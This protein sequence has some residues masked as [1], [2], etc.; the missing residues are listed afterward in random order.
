MEVFVETFYSGL[1]K[2]HIS[3]GHRNKESSCPGNQ[4]LFSPLKDIQ[5]EYALDSTR[6]CCTGE[7][8]QLVEL[9]TGQR[10]GHFEVTVGVTGIFLK[11]H[12]VNLQ[13]YIFNVSSEEQSLFYI[14][15]SLRAFQN[16]IFEFLHNKINHSKFSSRFSPNC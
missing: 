11:I 1:E 8:L 6:R 3:F 5:R 2:K 10:R 14:H 12:F 16:K 4:I 9:V 13:D 15:P 7:F